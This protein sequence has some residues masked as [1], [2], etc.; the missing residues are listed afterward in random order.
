[1]PSGNAHFQRFERD[2]GGVSG[3]L[4]AA[5]WERLWEELGEKRRMRK[6][7]TAAVAETALA[8]G[9][10]FIPAKAPAAF[11]GDF[12]DEAEGAVSFFF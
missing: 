3:A 4:L 5:R 7:S 1:M 2:S 10:A 6:G 8:W 9:S 11:A 12:A